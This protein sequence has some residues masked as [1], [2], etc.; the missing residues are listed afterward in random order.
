LVVG[1]TGKE[2]PINLICSTFTPLVS[3]LIVLGL[4]A[5][6]IMAGNSFLHLIHSYNPSIYTRAYSIEP[7]AIP[8][9]Q[10]LCHSSLRSLILHFSSLLST[11]SEV[12]IRMNC[13]PFIAWIQILFSSNF[14]E[15]EGNTRHP[16]VKRRKGK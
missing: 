6:M 8:N 2:T 9:T 16:N 12:F 7:C 1:G 15:K 11:S 13:A 4:R 10:H 5:P 14:N 3:P